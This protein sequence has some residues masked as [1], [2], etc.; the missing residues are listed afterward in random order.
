MIG[1]SSSARSPVLAR[2]VRSKI[3]ALIPAA[4]GRLAAFAGR[5]REPL[6]EVAGDEGQRRKFWEQVINGPVGEMVLA[7]REEEAARHIILKILT[8]SIDANQAE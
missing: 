5:F 6:K 7:G 4:Y 8:L 3:E 1:I 2:L